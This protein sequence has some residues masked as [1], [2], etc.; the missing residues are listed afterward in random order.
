MPV[1]AGYGSLLS[2]ASARETVPNL[3][4]FQLVTVRGYKRVFDKVAVVFFARHGATPDRRDIAA[5]S[6]RA[7]PGFEMTCCRFECDDE[8][9]LAL[10]EREHRYRWVMVDTVDAEG[11]VTPA[12]MTTGT[13]DEDYRLNKCVT[14][15]EYYRRVGQ[16]YPGRLWR[17]DVLPFPTYLS[18]ILRAVRS[19]SDEV[20]QDFLDTSFLAD[21]ETSI[22][23]Y[24]RITP[25]WEQG[26][27][28]SYSYLDD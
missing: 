26:A 18:H 17:D 25:D 1:V 20:Y 14:E 16:Y 5:C 3:R 27:G 11:R 23:D 2:E 7:E 9:F 24:I 10:Y 13:T 22:R 8:D 12:R 4:D 15:D 6:T 28:A 19:V 21:G